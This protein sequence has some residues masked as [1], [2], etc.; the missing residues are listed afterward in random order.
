MRKTCFV[1]TR[2][3]ETC[4]VEKGFSLIELLMATLIFTIFALGIFNCI[5]YSY[6]NII[7]SRNAEIAVNLCQEEMEVIKK[8]S[9]DFITCPA[10]FT[11]TWC[12]KISTYFSGYPTGDFPPVMYPGTYTTCK[13]D[14]EV[15]DDSAMCTLTESSHD[16]KDLLVYVGSNPGTQTIN[17]TKTITTQWIDD[18]NTTDTQDYIRVKVTIKWQEGGRERTRETSTDISEK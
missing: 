13:Y 1:E 14:T 10:T 17:G 5:N 6:K 7:T 12:I 2:F 9:Y 15:T 16:H 3:V 4:F 18:P 8:C 11:P